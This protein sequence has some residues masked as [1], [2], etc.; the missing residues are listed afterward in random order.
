MLTLPLEAG[1]VNWRVDVPQSLTN[2]GP[3]PQIRGQIDRNKADFRQVLSTQKERYE[4][5]GTIVGALRSI[6]ANVKFTPQI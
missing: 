3:T 1:C 4:I 5:D 6:Q 2:Q